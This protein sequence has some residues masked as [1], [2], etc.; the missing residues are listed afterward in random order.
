MSDLD[1]E[2]TI[3]KFVFRVRKAYRY[4]PEGLWVSREENRYRIGIGDFLQQKNGDVAYVELPHVGLQL[5]AGDVLITIE[6]MKTSFDVLSPVSGEVVAVNSELNDNPE[7][8]NE[9]PYGAGWLAEIECSSAPGV[10][11]DAPA[12]FQ[13]MSEEAAQEAAKLGR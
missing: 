5:E 6:T 11:L 2:T 1:L 7:R 9:D 4:T 13:V 3:D 12:Y 8:I 10:L